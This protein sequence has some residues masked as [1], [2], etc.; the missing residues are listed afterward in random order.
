MRQSRTADTPALLTNA[1]T[2]TFWWA[3]AILLFSLLPILAVPRKP[4]RPALT[5]P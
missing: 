2:E 1:F 3:A 5:S 4:R